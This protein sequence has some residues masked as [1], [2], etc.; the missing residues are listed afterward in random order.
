MIE[1]PL[2]TRH[3]AAQYGNMAKRP[4]RSKE[5]RDSSAKLL[6]QSR[7]PDYASIRGSLSKTAAAHK[8][9]AH[10]EEIAQGEP[11]RSRKRAPKKS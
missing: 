2:V 7:R 11:Q 3:E 9:L 6:K 4:S 5:H 10:E 8:M 1:N